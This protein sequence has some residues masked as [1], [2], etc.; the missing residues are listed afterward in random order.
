MF[1]SARIKLTA[2]YLLIIMLI[3]VSFSVAIYRMLTF[4]LNRVERIQRLRV[5]G[6]LPNFF[7]RNTMPT[8]YIDPDLIVETK[9]RLIT[10]LA[11]INLGILAASTF[12]GYFLAQKTLKPISNMLSEQNRFVSDSSHELRT[13]LTALKTEIEVSLRDQKLTLTQAKQLLLS[14]LEEV[15]HLQILSD[16]LLRLAQY[17]KEDSRLVF[18]NVFLPDIAQEAIRK[19]APLAKNKN[20]TI[21]NNIDNFAVNGNRTALVELFIILLDNA[22]KYSPQKTK[23]KISSIKKDGHVILKITDQGYGI[24]PH[25]LPHIFD[26]FYRSDA[27]RSKSE[28]PGYGLGLSI[29]KQIVTQHHGYIN[30]KSQVGK[31]S[32]V[33][34]ELPLSKVILS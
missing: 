21:S 2:W 28:T 18:S 14:N 26:R 32:T 29:A 22:I 13:P 10:T 20:V 16:N 7:S 4:E 19:I 12:A 34:L 17:Q 23:I 5:E 1:K 30:L 8:P 31:G 25:D 15:N 24:N 9:Q 27:S 3:S 33:V 11:L 6:R